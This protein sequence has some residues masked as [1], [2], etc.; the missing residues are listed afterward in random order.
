VPLAVDNVFSRE[1]VGALDLR[2][3]PPG[4]SSGRETG[5]LSRAALSI[6]Y[7]DRILIRAPT[8][9]DLAP[10]HPARAKIKAAPAGA[11]FVCVGERCSLPVEDAQA[12]AGA[13]AAMRA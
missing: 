7:P 3:R 1:R 6:P 12:I 11:A 13:V 2:L 10:D 5:A 4:S 9:T 8:D